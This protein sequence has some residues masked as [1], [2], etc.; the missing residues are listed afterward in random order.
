M[1]GRRLRAWYGL[2]VWMTDK[3]S[4]RNLVQ[5][6]THAQKYFQKLQKTVWSVEG[7]DTQN[8]NKGLMDSRKRYRETVKPRPR[9]E[10]IKPKEE[11]CSPVSVLAP[12]VHSPPVVPKVE[13]PV[14]K[15]E[16]KPE[17]VVF[18]RPNAASHSPSFDTHFYETDFHLD[19]PK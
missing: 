4:T 9:E 10:P 8:A 2:G 1:T 13:V 5:V 14:Q 12:E 7:N 6:R 16:P 15:Q 11:S 19:I 3:I 17:K 18:I